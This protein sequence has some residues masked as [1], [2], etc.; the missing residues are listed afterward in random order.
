MHSMPSL[1]SAQK[2][3]ENIKALNIDSRS[4]V[5]DGFQTP[6]FPI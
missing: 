1:E 5:Y 2:S 6:F 3:R 4:G